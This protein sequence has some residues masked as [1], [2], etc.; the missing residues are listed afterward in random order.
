M[1]GSSPN[2]VISIG[3]SGINLYQIVNQYHRNDFGKVN[4]LWCIFFQ[5]YCHKCQVP[6]M[7]CIVFLA[8][9]IRQIGLTHNIFHFICFQNKV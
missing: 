8:F 3:I 2:S 1:L 9:S 6:G 7:F 5:K 4:F